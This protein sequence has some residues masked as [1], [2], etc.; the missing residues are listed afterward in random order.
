M[1][2]SVISFF[3]TLA[4]TTFFLYSVID[5][6]RELRRFGELKGYTRFIISGVL[7][8]IFICYNP[9]HWTD[10]LDLNDS[11]IV[12]GVLEYKDGNFI[13]TG[14]G[15]DYPDWDFSCCDSVS[16]VKL[17]CKDKEIKVWHNNHVVYQVEKNGKILYG[18]TRNNIGIVFSN[19]THIMLYVMMCAFIVDV[20]MNFDLRLKGLLEDEERRKF[21]DRFVTEEKVRPVKR[22]PESKAP[23]QV[24]RN[25]P[26]TNTA[27][28]QT[29]PKQPPKIRPTM[30]NEAF[31]TSNYI[32]S[33]IGKILRRFCKH[34]GTEL[35]ETE[36]IRDSN[37]TLTDIVYH[38]Y[39]FCP[40]CGLDSDPNM[41][42]KA[43]D[44][45]DWKVL[46]GLILI[47]SPFLAPILIIMIASGG[48]DILLE[49]LGITVIIF[50]I[51]WLFNEK[52]HDCPSCGRLYTKENFCPN[53]G[54]YLK[55]D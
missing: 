37:G 13:L 31:Y 54:T 23:Q 11:E 44:N 30:S 24:I 41:M 32:S 2:W 55:K 25:I 3:M 34:C 18:I 33:D 14:S 27:T 15:D 4:I 10:T 48:I 40:N 7:C 39:K 17:H 51:V 38:Q 53:C 42:I 36:E 9:P 20:V 21:E 12:A 52:I 5:S 35:G 46:I 6:I 1:G 50:F 45:D 29:T 43:K 22:V 16:M 26:R 19:L 28:I 8:I 49:C 47:M